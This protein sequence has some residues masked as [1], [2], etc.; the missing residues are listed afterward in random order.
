MVGGDRDGM[1][2]KKCY[3]LTISSQ[4]HDK[5]QFLGGLSLK[6]DADNRKIELTIFA[7]FDG[8][9]WS[10]PNEFAEFRELINKGHI[11]HLRTLDETFVLRS[12]GKWSRD[13]DV[14]EGGCI[15]KDCI[16]LAADIEILPI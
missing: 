1:A 13:D 4:G 10:I 15:K 2:G 11:V 16:A 6:I 3:I 12:I 9:I 14:D 5:F 8:F 7:D